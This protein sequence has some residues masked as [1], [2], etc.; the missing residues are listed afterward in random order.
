MEPSS[1]QAARARRKVA[2]FYVRPRSRA[3]LSGAVIMCKGGPA[4][5]KT[6]KAG[7]EDNAI[8]LARDLRNITVREQ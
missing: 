5:P 8:H 4:S 3:K 2:S 1:R 7:V 6:R